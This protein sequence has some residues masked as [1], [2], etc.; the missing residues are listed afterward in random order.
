MGMDVGQC[1]RCSKPEGGDGLPAAGVTGRCEPR[2][3]G[4]GSPTKFCKSNE[5][6]EP[7]HPGVEV[8]GVGT[9][10]HVYIQRLAEC[11]GV[12]KAVMFYLRPLVLTISCLSSTTTLNL[13]DCCQVWT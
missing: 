9:P 3:V 12:S 13:D 1:K 4:A 11:L 8:L 6:S 10:V 7:T 5:G 2:G